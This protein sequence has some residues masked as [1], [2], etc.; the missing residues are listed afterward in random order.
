MGFV[1]VEDGAAFGR[2]TRRHFCGLNPLSCYHKL[3]GKRVVP[4]ENDLATTNPNLA[5]QWHPSRNLPL[6]P[7]GVTAGTARLL[8]WVCEIGHEW[9]APGSKRLSGRGCPVCSGRR[10]DVGVNDLATTNPS[11]SLQWHPS[12]NQNLNP[13]NVT[14]GGGARVWWLCEKGH[15]WEATVGHRA[16]G[17]GCPVCLNQAILVGFNDLTTTHSHVAKLWH[18]TKNGT[19]TPEAV[20]AGSSK[21]VWWICEIGHDSEATVISRAK[22]SRCPVCLNQIIQPGFNDLA[23]TNPEI[24]KQWHPTKNG[25]FSPEAVSARSG[26]KVWWICEQSHSWLAPTADRVYGSGCPFCSGRF[27]ISGVNDLAT[28]HPKIAAQWHP[29][30][31]GDLL[32]TEVKAATNKRIWWLCSAGHEWQAVVAARTS[33]NGCPV[34]GG[35]TVLSGVND[36]QTTHPDLSA[37]W[38][39][40]KNGDRSA[41]QV[42]AGSGKKAWWKC[43]S[44][45]DWQATGASRVK[46]SGCPICSGFST[47]AGFNDLATTHPDLASEWHPSRNGTLLPTDITSGSSRRLWWVCD[48]GH[49]WESICSHRAAGSGCPTCTGRV[50][51]FGF[52][53]LSTTHPKI[54]GQWHPELNGT[55]KAKDVTAG[56][57]KKIWWLCTEGHEWN[58][59]VT[60]RVRGSGCPI[61]AHYGFDPSQPALL[62]FIANSQLGARKIGITNVGTSRLESFAKDGWNQVFLLQGEVGSVIRLVETQLFRW[63]R[64]EHALPAFLGREEMRRIGGWTETFSSEGPTDLEIIERIK[65]EYAELSTSGQV[66]FS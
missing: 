6:L 1:S 2:C 50:A 48:K 36:L 46:G 43:S 62:Y 57:N 18:P 37:E 27:A 51:L 29:T 64:I 31:N 39:P 21:K 45:H 17:T 11:L 4:G 55:L 22:G 59:I 26:K 15:E 16:R 35:K 8:W 38:H 25:A 66:N 58:A 24:A 34:C 32:T 9:Q 3:M 60:S 61:C 65:A 41:S 10:V 20:S 33:G 47:L 28:T 52:N 23:S 13:T 63:L 49:E 56:A 40:T 30:K 54:A 42:I 5:A 19:L 12:K 7:S 14:A 44:G 53:D